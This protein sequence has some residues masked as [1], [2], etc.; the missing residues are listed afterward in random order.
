MEIRPGKGGG[1]QRRAA[2]DSCVKGM[3]EHDQVESWVVLCARSLLLGFR[4][5]ICST[6]G[7]NQICRCSSL[8]VK[9][10]EDARPRSIDRL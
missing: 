2:G 6:F 9:F 5:R 3:G 1:G 4:L 8:Q 7:Q 10:A